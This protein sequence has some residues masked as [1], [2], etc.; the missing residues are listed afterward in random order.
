MMIVLLKTCTTGDIF[1]NI[2]MKDI[3]DIFFP[4]CGYDQGRYREVQGGTGRD[5]REKHGSFTSPLLLVSTSWKILEGDGEQ[6]LRQ[7]TA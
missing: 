2:C 3:R 6:H 7:Y 1:V 4:E 5:V